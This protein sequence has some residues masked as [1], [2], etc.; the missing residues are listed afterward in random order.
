MSELPSVT[1][2]DE[3]IRASVPLFPAERVPLDAASGR[4]LRQQV[5]AERD[6]P[7]FDR[8]M[9]DGIAISLADA[10]RREFTVN[11]RQMAGMAGAVLA[12][13]A[14]CI[15]VTTGAMLPA[16]CN[17][18][19]P[20]EQVVHEGD[21]VTLLEGWEPTARQFIHP[22]GSDCHQGDALLAPGVRLRAPELAVLAANGV[23]EVEVAA[24]PK[25]AIIATGDELA[26]VSQQPLADGQIR[27]SNDRALAAA[28][29]DRGFVDVQLTRVPDDLAA[30]TARLGELLATCGVLVLSGGVSVGQRDFVPEALRALGVDK[31]LHRLAQRPGKPMWFGI[32][33]QGQVAFALPGNPVSALVCAVR[34]L[35]PALEQAMGL[36]P[37][38]PERVVL[39]APAV[40]SPALTCFVPVRVHHDD[41][42][43]AVAT[44]VPAPTSGDFSALP[45]TDGVVELAPSAEPAPAG[46]VAALYRW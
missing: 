39:A 36:A 21:R 7:P 14:G 4:V 41:A 44:P 31:V 22:R 24:V 9:M 17:C 6:Q 1:E 40:T 23:T 43:R 45:G 13:P 38:P 29:R 16:G 11:G 42:G 34:H 3:R 32:G 46:T 37:R 19:V 10:G 2:A 28:L 27:R 5:R 20:I 26:E 25:V 35:L 30:T 8:V 18:V 33:P 15:E 12:D